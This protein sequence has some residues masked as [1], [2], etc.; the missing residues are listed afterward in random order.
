MARAFVFVLDSFGIGGSADA[1]RYGDAGADTFG[2]IAQA[3]AAGRGDR[4]GVRRGPLLLPNM[5]SLGLS[6]AARTATGFSFDGAAVMGW[7]HFPSRCAAPARSHIA[8]IHIAIET[9]KVLMQTSE[10]TS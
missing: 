4:D 7:R 6:E 1:D 3:C 10:T 8:P 9:R 5:L 2:H